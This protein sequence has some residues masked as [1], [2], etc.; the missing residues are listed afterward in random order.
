MPNDP[1]GEMMHEAKIKESDMCRC[2]SNRVCL[3]IRTSAMVD[4]TRQE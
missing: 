2:R 1:R 4:V 3:E